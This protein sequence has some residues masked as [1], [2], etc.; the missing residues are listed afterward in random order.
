LVSALSACGGGG[1][2]PL[3]TTSARGFRLGDLT[4]THG[5]RTVLR[6]TVEI[7]DTEKAREQG[8]MGVRQ[9][10]D[11]QGMVFLWTSPQNA[12]FWMKDT[13]IALDVA[14]WDGT[15]TV[16]DEQSMTPCPADPCPTYASSRPYV[17]AV[18]V[19]GGLLARS[20]LEPGDKVTFAERS[21]SAGGSG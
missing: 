11:Q 12:Q 19:R 17:G 14:F 21:R 9:L 15:R 20:G 10:T 5:G 1:G 16:V 3:Q 8:L 4:V 7:A 18:E 13:P 2:A 6:L